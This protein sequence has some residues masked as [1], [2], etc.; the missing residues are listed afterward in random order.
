MDEST[1]LSLQAV[2]DLHRAWTKKNPQK[3]TADIRAFASRYNG[4]K[5]FDLSEGIN[6]GFVRHKILQA[7]NL[8]RPTAEKLSSTIRGGANPSSFEFGDLLTQPKATVR[9]GLAKGVDMLGSSLP[10]AGLSAWALAGGNKAR[11]LKTLGGLL[12]YGLISGYNE[13]RDVPHAITNAVS[14]GASPLLAQKGV[15]L[16]SKA[17]G[18]AVAKA[19]AGIGGG[20]AGDVAEIG[21]APTDNPDDSYL[22][23]FRKNL[24]EFF[25]DPS[26]VISLGV[27][28]SVFGATDKILEHTKKKLAAREEQVS[29]TPGLYTTSGKA[30][31]LK[32]LMQSEFNLDIPNGVPDSTLRL[33]ADA[34]RLGDSEEAQRKIYASVRDRLDESQSSR[35]DQ[36]KKL[37]EQR[38]AEY[39]ATVD[40]DWQSETPHLDEFAF[41]FKSEKAAQEFLNNSL[42]T[43]VPANSRQVGSRIFYWGS[44]DV[45]LSAM[46][47]QAR[48]GKVHKMSLRGSNLFRNPALRTVTQLTQPRFVSGGK[49]VVAAALRTNKE[50]LYKTDALLKEM[51]KRMPHDI[52]EHYAETLPE[53]ES[54]KGFIHEDQLF[55]AFDRALPELEVRSLLGNS[56]SN[57]D[58]VLEATHRLETSG[59]V[60][61]YDDYF[62]KSFISDPEGVAVTLETLSSYPPHLRTDLE[63]VLRHD[64][65]AEENAEA[66]TGRYGVEPIKVT[67]MDRPVDLLLRQRRKSKLT[68]EDYLAE[69]P[70]SDPD[71]VKK[72]KNTY[73]DVKKREGL[74]YTGPHFGGADENVVASV[75]GYFHDPDTYFPFEIQSDWAQSGKKNGY[76]KKGSEKPGVHPSPYLARYER[77]AL[78]Q[79]IVHAKEGGATRI[80]LPDAETAMM[81]E[82][83]D[84]YAVSPGEPGFSHVPQEGGMRS[85]YGENG[86]L[87]NTLKKLGA[88]YVGKTALG[89][90]TNREASD[91]FNG[92]D[93]ITGFEFDIS[94]VDVDGLTLFRKAEQDTQQAELLNHEIMV[95][96]SRLQQEMAA[97]GDLMTTADF[98][99]KVKSMTALGKAGSD[100]DTDVMLR[101]MLRIAG[102][103][104]LLSVF[105]D[106]RTVNGY[107]TDGFSSDDSNVVGLN[108]NDATVQSA[109]QTAAHEMT[110]TSLADFKRVDLEGYRLLEESVMSIDA[111]Q[112]SLLVDE[113]N[114][115]Y[116]LKIDANYASGKE[117]NP[118][119]PDYVS[120]VA[121]ERMAAVSEIVIGKALDSKPT[122]KLLSALPIEVQ[123]FIRNLMD[124]MRNWFTGD[125]RMG[126][127][128]SADSQAIFDS[129]YDKMDK[130]VFQSEK[131]ADALA[132]MF[133]AEQ[134]F[135]PRTL[136]TPQ[137][138]ELSKS[139]V[140]RSKLQKDYVNDL[141][142]MER[143]SMSWAQKTLWSTLALTKTFPVARPLFERLHN[144]R[145]EIQKTLMTYFGE[146]G[147]DSKHSLTHEA[148]MDGFEKWVHDV[149][150]SE[151]RLSKISQV[152][153]ADQNRR[154]DKE[155]LPG[156]TIADE[157]VSADEMRDTYKMPDEDI[158]MVERIRGLVERVAYQEFLDMTHRD[159]LNQATFLLSHFGG[160]LSDLKAEEIGRTITTLATEASKL[161]I[162]ALQATK[163]ED[164]VGALKARRLGNVKKE[165]IRLRLADELN[166]QGIEIKPDDPRIE[167]AVKIATL[168]GDYRIKHILATSK[169]G[170]APQVRRGNYNLS[171]TKKDGTSF[172]IGFNTKKEAE[173]WWSKN[174]RKEGLTNATYSKK[175]DLGD[176]YRHYTSET[177]QGIRRQYRNQLNSLIA[178]FDPESLSEQTGDVLTQLQQQFGDMDKELSDALGQ[179]ADPFKLKR[180]DIAGFQ[181]E[182]YLPNIFDYINIKTIIG[183][184]GIISA[185]AKFE[186]SKPEFYQ[187]KDLL[188]QFREI[189]DYTL[190]SKDSEWSPA[191]KFI[192]MY[193]LGLSPRHLFQNITQPFLIGVPELASITGSFSEAPRR[194]AKAYKQVAQWN[195]KGTTGNP[196]LDRL[197]KQAEDEQVWNPSMLQHYLPTQDLVSGPVTTTRFLRGQAG[198]LKKAKIQAMKANRHVQKVLRVTAESSEILN[199]QVAFAARAN[200]V[201]AGASTT[202]LE[203]LYT[204]SSRFTNDVNFVGDKSNRPGFIR[205]AGSSHGPLMFATSLMS[206][207]LNHISLQ[208]S[209]WNQLTKGSVDMKSY[210]RNPDKFRL[211]NPGAYGLLMGVGA[212]VAFSG[213]MGLPFAQDADEVVEDLTG[214][215]FS[216][217]VRSGIIDLGKQFDLSEEEGD[218][219]ADAVMTGLPGAV[220]VGI[221]QSVGLGRIFS[222]QTGKPFSFWDLLGAGGSII[223]RGQRSVQAIASDPTNPD[224]W[225]RAV[226][227]AMPAGLQYWH[228]LIN[229]VKHNKQLDSEGRVV[230][231]PLDAGGNI[232]RLLGFTPS[233]VT[234]QR[235]SEFRA[236][237]METK[238]SRG[239]VDTAQKIGRMMF[240]ATSKKDKNLLDKAKKKYRDYVRSNR[241]T[242]AQRQ[243][244]VQSI[245]QDI[246]SRSG[247]TIDIPN[248][249]MASILAEIQQSNPD[250]TPQVETRFD[251]RQ[252]AAR[253]AQQLG[254]PVALKL[255]RPSSGS[256]RNQALYQSLINNGVNPV[257]AQMIAS[258]RYE[259]VENLKGQPLPALRSR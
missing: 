216:D 237:R 23:R 11:A 230:S 75:R 246:K 123:R 93:N 107:G 88:R 219:V 203:S 36:L 175:E 57:I 185:R 235:A 180:K 104:K 32:K 30:D 51:K 198:F 35:F 91:Y 153:E 240:E 202:D 130:Q 110:H 156:E 28:E 61:E 87:V 82:G 26:N 232:S 16:V 195:S 71:R 148:A 99:K 200:E 67:E 76:R 97:S 254:D 106:S 199:R 122:N 105:N 197:M 211:D 243:G 248:A 242:V 174:R 12:P 209:Y 182:D 135:D 204:E 258:K 158:Q 53:F 66:A 50:G 48:S 228:E 210:K 68:F 13:S 133:Q 124:K 178:S 101:M 74:M 29:N 249:R 55:N 47:E 59:F 245:S 128:F 19:L 220:G 117:F 78:Q 147:Q 159:Y 184:K 8:A 187:N 226:R 37:P 170:Y 140:L 163:A 116:G 1:P 194:M 192:Y 63:K 172:N 10:S 201:K 173:I 154:S 179:K 14:L 188:K 186:M 56:Q 224:S 131:A 207:V 205:R 134:A 166:S 181:K 168:Q 236:R 151:T 118:G 129:V 98:V 94:K 54:E 2:H 155:S 162:T 25:K 31:N 92:K 114:K 125:A 73:A 164:K 33:A 90:M 86:S 229:V 227:K 234:Q 250:Y 102:P 49:K 45:A 218:V 84:S 72:A 255:A 222:F 241:L 58:P 40:R 225:E 196:A 6:A 161:E 171:A 85:H 176:H 15:Q 43:D 42:D 139:G 239:R 44:D 160:S 191:R 259:D 137:L 231:N 177:L 190:N 27:G 60:M 136:G 100:F 111:D 141:T 212:L 213:A 64:S 83:H 251:K 20:M 34:A 9:E 208:M 120:H 142:F 126:R 215:R 119:I 52:V 62:D 79:A 244:L 146:L 167:Q 41:N 17:G 89:K 183:Q 3:N 80:V 18:G 108:L 217:M 138:S 189:T 165:E 233:E 109:L 81:I 95:K 256:I 96:L 5:G 127:Y 193:F 253:T 113:A 4:V 150:M 223:Q 21:A 169:E 38:L 157:L 22:D 132:K 77:L 238:I 149:A 214:M 121:G 65:N 115:L 39:T 7:A 24:P 103:D 144:Y 46:S 143:E 69:Y 145:A 257:I 206:F 252:E 221:N 247:Q 70:E 112:F 152:F